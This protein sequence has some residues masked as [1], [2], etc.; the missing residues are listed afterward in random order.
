MATTQHYFWALG[1]F[2]LLAASLRYF[3]AWLAFK[4][5]S[6]LWYKASFSGALVSYAIVCQKS[7]GIPQPNMTYVRRALLDENVQ[8]FLL[9]I[10]WWSSRKPIAI[11]LLPYMIFSLFHALTFTRTTLLPRFL[12]PGPPSTA[13]GA[14][15]PHPYA[16][17]LQVW[18]KANYDPAM[19]VVAYTE[20][21]ILARVVLGAITFQNA[22]LAPIIFA[23]FL[24]Q[25]YY[26]SVFTRDAITKATRFIDGYVI[27]ANNPIV[28]QIY[29]K[30]KALIEQWVGSV[31][32]PNSPQGARR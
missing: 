14:P 1:H 26:Q 18:V 25:R 8:Y 30:L 17:K 22:I 19:K 31:I 24:R 32:E 10:Y 4:S 12:P 3:L 11:T 15:G 5:I 21:I 28:S 6:T 7:L 16:K 27:K 20:L 9:A 23:H 29:A 13:N 2:V